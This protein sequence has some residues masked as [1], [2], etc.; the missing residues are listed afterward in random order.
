MSLLPLPVLIFLQPSMSQSKQNQNNLETE[1]KDEREQPWKGYFSDSENQAHAEK[2]QDIVTFGVIVN[3][4]AE[5][6]RCG[7][8]PCV[9]YG[10]TFVQS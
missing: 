8:D 10:A 7:Q 2:G 3:Q 5:C 1:A 6:S 9:C 4:D